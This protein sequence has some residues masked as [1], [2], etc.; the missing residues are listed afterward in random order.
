MSSQRQKVPAAVDDASRSPRRR[1]VLEHGVG[2]RERE[3]REERKRA[4]GDSWADAFCCADSGCRETPRR[5]AL[6]GS[7]TPRLRR[8]RRRRRSGDGVG[9]M[10]RRRR[11]VRRDR[12]G[13]AL[14]LRARRAP[15][16]ARAAYLRTR[17]RSGRRRRCRSSCRSSASVASLS[18]RDAV[19]GAGGVRGANASS[20]SRPAR[21]RG[22]QLGEA[23]TKHGRAARRRAPRS[24]TRCSVPAM[25]G[26]TSNRR[27][28][29]G[30]RRRLPEA[31]APPAPSVQTCATSRAARR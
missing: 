12:V 21:R 20:G 3:E 5:R 17:R 30:N 26:T 25:Q 14:G 1:R 28:R 22:L 7:S 16:R 4:R 31:S 13:D 18:A 9:V 15:A 24:C 6:H 19:H 27:R 8:A 11:D 29:F 2:K 10:S 23:T